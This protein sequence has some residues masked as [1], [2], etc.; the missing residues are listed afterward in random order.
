MIGPVAYLDYDLR[1]TRKTLQQ[2]LGHLEG[3][4]HQ[5]LHRLLL[6]NFHVE[7]LRDASVLPG[8][9]LDL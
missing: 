1:V 4:V 8:Q 6:H 3:D 5:Q 9:T 7:L 2:E